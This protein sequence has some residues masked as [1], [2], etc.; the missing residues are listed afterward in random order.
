M[1]MRDRL[2]LDKVLS[3]WKKEAVED[4]AHAIVMIS[5][6]SYGKGRDIKIHR[7][8]EIPPEKLKALLLATA[9]E[10]G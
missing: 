8:F 7:A 2:Q 1:N 6:P 4:N 5:M 9:A 10:L 3:Q